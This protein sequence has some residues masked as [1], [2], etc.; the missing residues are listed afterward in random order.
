MKIHQRPET[1]LGLPDHIVGMTTEEE[2][3][4]L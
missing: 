3:V 1:D 2:K 4:I